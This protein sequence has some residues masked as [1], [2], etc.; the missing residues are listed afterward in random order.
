LRESEEEQ[1][2]V[3]FNNSDKA[4]ELQVPLNGTPAEKMAG[5]SLLF[6]NG[7]A[8]LNGHEIQ[9]T[10]PAQSLSIFSLN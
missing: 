5:I 3:A 9:L 8:E 1:V 6:G 2:A 4:R 7:K 10:L